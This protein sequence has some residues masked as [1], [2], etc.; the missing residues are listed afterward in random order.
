MKYRKKPVIVEAWHFTN[1]NKE[2][3]L[4]DLLDVQMNV[5]PTFDDNNQPCI[6]IPTLEGE[7]TASLG[8]YIIKG[9]QGELYPCKP[10]IFEQTYEEVADSE[11]TKEEFEK[12][13]IYL[14]SKIFQSYYCMGIYE[15]A[16]ED[17]TA[18]SIFEKIGLIE[19]QENEKN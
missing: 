16:E 14:I 19:V 3:V 11:L 4:W 15:I 7:M 8:D 6:K 17:E 9:V 5:Y 1:K 13:E 2:I 12:N 18:K 10:D